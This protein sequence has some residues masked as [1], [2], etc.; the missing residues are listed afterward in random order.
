M[1]IDELSISG[2]SI[3]LVSGAIGF[4]TFVNFNAG[5]NID[6][7]IVNSGQILWNRDNYLQKEIDAISGSIPPIVSDVNDLN[8]GQIYV[9]SQIDYLSGVLFTTGGVSGQV[10]TNLNPT[11]VAVGGIPVGT[12]FNNLTFQ[13]V[14]DMMFYPYQSPAFSSFYIN[15]QST[16]IEVG[17][18]IPAVV[19]DF[20]WTTTNSSNINT[21]SIVI[22]DVT[23]GNIV[24]GSSL[25]NTGTASLGLPNNIKKTTNTSHVWSVTGTNTHSSTFTSNFTVNWYWRYYYGFYSGS[26]IN[27]TET[28]ALQSSTLASSRAGN[29]ILPTNPG[30]LNYI[31]FVYPNSFGALTSI[32]DNTNSFN[33]TGD[34]TNIGTITVTN[35]NSIDNIYTV[36]RSINAVGGASGN[37]YTLT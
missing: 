34:F 11:T 10:Y 37:N 19:V 30:G 6:T 24:L 25:P 32:Y 21:N 20:I 1:Y 12:T 28:L 26:I 22:K 7:V 29:F 4:N 33:V 18:T 9:Q 16:F 35:V 23:S 36:Y 17:T 15:A 2:G 31:Y 8:S 13:Q 3:E 5:T 14:F 27:S